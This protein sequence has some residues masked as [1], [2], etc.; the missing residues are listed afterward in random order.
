MQAKFS[1]PALDEQRCHE[2]QIEKPATEFTINRARKS[3]RERICRECK[4][5]RHAAWYAINGS[6]YDWERNLRKKFGMAAADY[7]RMLSA[8]GGG[9][10]I[11]GVKE[12]GQKGK[13]R[14]DVDHCH[15]CGNDE[16]GK[17]IG[18]PLSVR[19]LLCSNC[20]AGNNWDKVPDWGLSAHYYLQAHHCAEV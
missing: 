6:R 7:D 10:A 17:P 11:C 18:N 12:P 5:R 3:G 9:C 15:Q 8:Q 2:C 4:Q 16:N 20:N 13:D 1:I 19:G 14:F